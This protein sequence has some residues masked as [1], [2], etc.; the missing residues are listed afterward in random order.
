MFC[1][2]E[3]NCR[4]VLCDI[5]QEILPNIPENPLM[6][7]FKFIIHASTKV[8]IGYENFITLITAVD[9]ESTLWFLF[10]RKRKIN[11]QFSCKARQCVH[12]FI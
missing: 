6:S 8:G 1:R 5:D 7:P 4:F 2:L 12:V 11:F 9:V 3:N 10:L